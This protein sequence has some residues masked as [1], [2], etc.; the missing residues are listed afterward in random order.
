M[1]VRCRQ[2]NLRMSLSEQEARQLAIVTLTMQIMQTLR[3]GYHRIP[4]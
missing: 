4:L 3:T 2:L 1:I